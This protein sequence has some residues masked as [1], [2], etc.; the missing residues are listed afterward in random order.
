[1]DTRLEA[2]PQIQVE[3]HIR[4]Q[5]KHSRHYK[6]L[7][8]GFHSKKAVHPAISS[9][10]KSATMIITSMTALLF[11]QNNRV[12]SRQSLPSTSGKASVLF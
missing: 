1:M 9:E 6:V 3:H 10:A 8:A 7:V 12:Y 4:Y 2:E 5:L 11:R